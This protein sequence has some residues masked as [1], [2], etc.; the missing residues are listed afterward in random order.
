MTRGVALVGPTASGKSQLA[1]QFA[2]ALSDVEIA[3]VDAMTVYRG[4]DIGTAKPTAKERADVTYHLLDLVDPSEEFTVAQFQRSAHQVAEEAAT[5]GVTVL[6]VGGTGLYGRAVVDDLAIPGQ[7][8]EVRAAI[9]QRADADLAG[10][11]AELVTLDP[12]AAVRTTAKNRRRIVCALEV[13]IGAGRPFSSFGPGLST[14]GPAAVAQVGLRVSLTEL[15][16]RIEARLAQWMQDGLLSEVQDLAARPVGLSRTA[17]Q[18]VGYR[19]LLAHVAGECALDD[20]VAAA[21]T[22]TKRLARRQI[23]W[24]NRDPRIEWLTDPAD[25][26]ARLAQLVGQ[27]APTTT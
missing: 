6:Y 4:M 5:R 18:A 27:T 19:E 23:K 3:C 21:V 14:Y 13:T 20:A 1:H 24:F 8:P 9:E 25:A 7:F 26:A 2:A 22:A 12:V 15:D 11:Y 10:V 17:R 16:S